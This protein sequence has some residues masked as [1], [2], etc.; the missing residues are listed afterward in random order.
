[1]KVFAVDSVDQA[2][3]DLEQ[4]GGTLGTAAHG[5]PAGPG[6]HSVPTDWQ[7]SPWS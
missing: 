6:G 5:P 4:L 2:L 3:A 1:L 7:D